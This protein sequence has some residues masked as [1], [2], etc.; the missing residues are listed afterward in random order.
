M[1][2]YTLIASTDA[3]TKGW[4]PCAVLSASSSNTA[5]N[6][7]VSLRKNGGLS[8][9][10]QPARFRI[11]RATRTE[12][13]LMMGFFH[14]LGSLSDIVGTQDDLD[15]LFAR[16]KKLLLS[17]F[18]GIFID[19]DAMKKRYL[20][21]SPFDPDT[22]STTSSGG[23]EMSEGKVTSLQKETE[24]P[25]SATPEVEA[26]AETKSADP[27]EEAETG[28]ETGNEPTQTDD[29]ETEMG[30]FS[31]ASS[32]AVDNSSQE[33]ALAQILASSE[34]NDGGKSRDESVDL[35]IL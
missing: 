2:H 22:F 31:E 29:A 14:S 9:V 4:R 8:F 19:F 15:L 11:R 12:V 24:S 26:K 10:A 18:M 25:E 5:A 27:I 6:Q 34:A 7:A 23:T 20:N 16:R 35:G 32:E 21:N 33:D 30:A 13:A 1:A 17:F 28:N 3:D